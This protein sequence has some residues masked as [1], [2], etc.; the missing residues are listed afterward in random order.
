MLPNISLPSDPEQ[1]AEAA[2]TRLRTEQKQLSDRVSHAR[3]DMTRHAVAQDE[4]DVVLRQ[5]DTIDEEIAQ[6]SSSAG[7]F[8]SALAELTSFITDETCPVCD[9]AP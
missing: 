6:L 3:V 4:R 1:F 8:G 7:T 5:R 9:R 2:L